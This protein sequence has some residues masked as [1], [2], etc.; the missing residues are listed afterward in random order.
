MRIALL[1]VLSILSACDSDKAV[2][3]FNNDPTASI[4]SHADG[5]EVTE[6][7]VTTF[8]GSVSDAN[9]DT[10]S[11]TAT[12]FAGTEEICPSTPPEDDGTV[13]C[14]ATKTVPIFM[15]NQ[16]KASQNLRLAT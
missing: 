13:L 9:H 14:K 5:D 7:I 2:K 3:A 4:T 6:G 8:R 16:I 1:G 12:W 11:L 15:Q 10:S